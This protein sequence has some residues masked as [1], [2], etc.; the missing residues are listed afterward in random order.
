MLSSLISVGLYS[1]SFG[2]GHIFG[3]IIGANLTHQFGFRLCSDI[4]ATS[5]L[6]VFI[7]LGVLF[8]VQACLGR[9]EI[10]QS[11]ETATT[12]ADAEHRQSGEN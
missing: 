10:D 5:C 3:P 2:V 6:V 8:A 7:I 11:T 4:I 12:L 9:K 1:A